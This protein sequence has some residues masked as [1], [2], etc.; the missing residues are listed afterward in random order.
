MSGCEPAVYLDNAA[1]SSPKPESVYQGM[2]R[3]LREAGANPGCSAHRLAVSAASAVAQTRRLLARFFNAPAPERVAFT[4]N[5]TDALNLLR[6]LPLSDDRP[7]RGVDHQH[8][9]RLGR[10]V[11]TSDQAAP[12]GRRCA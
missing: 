3:F 1:T 4:L 10:A 8:L 11:D 6:G 7:V 12:A 5:A 9:R 2:D